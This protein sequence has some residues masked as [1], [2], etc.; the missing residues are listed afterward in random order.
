[1]SLARLYFNARSQ[2]IEYSISRV[3]DCDGRDVCA[4]AVHLILQSVVYKHLYCRR[5]K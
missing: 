4:A 5:G 1:M 2:E 3:R